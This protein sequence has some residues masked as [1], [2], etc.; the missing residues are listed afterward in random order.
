MNQ[1][2]WNDFVSF[3]VKP[4]FFPGCLARLQE[5]FNYSIPYVCRTL[6]IYGPFDCVEI[7]KQRVHFIVAVIGFYCYVVSPEYCGWVSSTELQS[8]L[9]EF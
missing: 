6:G 4:P 3:G 9:L 2:S 7:C 5:G 1:E 8:S